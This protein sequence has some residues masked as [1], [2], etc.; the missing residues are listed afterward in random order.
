MVR[1]D[2]DGRRA[3]GCFLRFLLVLVLILLAVGAFAGFYSGATPKVTLKPERPGIGRRTPIQIRIEDPQRVEKVRVE[4][5]QNSDV[6]PV[7]EKA[8]EPQPAWKVWGAP[9]PVI[10]TAEVGR[11][12]VQG[13]RAG[14]ATIRVTAER[15]GSLLRRPDPVVAE[16]KLPVRLA[17]P[18]IQIV[19][20]FHYVNQG[21]SELVVYRVGEGA[22]RDGVQSYDWFFPGFPVPGS[23]DRQLRFALFAVPY[24]KSDASGVHLIA[25]DEVGNRAEA[26]FIDKYTPR[27]M[28]TDTILVTDAFMNKVVPEILSQSPEV[29]DQGGLLKNYIEINRN[30]RKKNARTLKE[31]AA[32]SEPKFLWDLPFQPMPNAAITAAFAQRRT[33]DYNGKAIDV[34]DHL[35][36]DMASVERDAIPASNTGKVVLARFFGIYGNAVVIDHGYGLM[37]LYGHLS[38]I[39][40]KEG[41]AVQRGQELGRSGQ[42]GLAGGDHLHFTMLLQGLAISPVEWWDPHWIQDRV[43]RKLGPALP[44]RESAAPPA[45]AR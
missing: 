24:D 5:I 7:L 13:L 32:K 22:L 28:T 35:G 42:T 9:P 19:S 6:K 36:F 8:F 14:E 11:D 12:T 18:T 40:V 4:L 17:P 25:E 31:L 44:Y 2:R 23:N 1:R 10:L 43:A 37:S 3:A 26:S 16:V 45:P 39:A 33:Y 21:G 30:L 34:E 29:S 20:S 27:P 41:Q 15:A 38:S